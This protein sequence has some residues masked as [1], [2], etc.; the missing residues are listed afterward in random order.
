VATATKQSGGATADT[1]ALR[2]FLA[3]EG[4]MR[5]GALLEAATPDEV[6]AAWARGEVEFGQTKY[7]VTG[8]PETNITLHNGVVIPPA[9]VVIEGGVEWTGPKQ[10][11]HL[12]FA[13]LRAERL[14]ACPRYQKYQLEVCVNKEKDVWEWLEEGQAPGRR[15]TRYARRDIDRA[16]AER[17]FDLHVRLTDRGLGAAGN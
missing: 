13:R 15:E 9:A 16:E 7:V 12:P 14:P 5:L 8:N 6:A 17:L 2:A 11:W 10:R 3:A 4:E 1:A